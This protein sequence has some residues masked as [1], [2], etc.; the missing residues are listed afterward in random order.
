MIGEELIQYAVAGTFGLAVIGIT[1]LIK[2][3]NLINERFI[4]VISLGI[5]V[6]LAFLFIQAPVREILIVGILAGLSAQ[7]L[8]GAAKKTFLE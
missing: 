3:M 2:M 8:Y 1:Q 7:G 6:G 4:P 5:S